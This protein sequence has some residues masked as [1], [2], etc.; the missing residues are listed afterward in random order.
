VNLRHL[1]LIVALTRVRD[2]DVAAERLLAA[3]RAV[4]DRF[5][6]YR[7]MFFLGAWGVIG[8]SSVDQALTAQRRLRAM[9]DGPMEQAAVAHM[10]GL[11]RGMRGEFEE[12]RRL[13]REARARAA[14]FGGDMTGVP[15]ARDEALV[16]R[17]AGDATA[18]ERTLRPACD[19]L[20]AAGDVGFLSLLVG[21]L[22][23]ALYELG[24]YREAAEANQESERA[25]QPADVA[26]EVVWR[27]VR[28]KLLA[29]EG[30][31]EAAVSLAREAIAW[32]ETTDVLEMVGDAYRDLS[33]VE[34]LGGRPEKAASALQRA[35]AAYERKGL[36]PMAERTRK[37]LEELRTAV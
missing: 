22:A 34:R 6:S 16:E 7:A 3:A 28:A 14:D 20:R 35:L 27:R 1:E 17:Y 9:A 31:Y 13:I 32:A 24:R 2:L 30:N 36:V 23:D 29:R 4:G 5:G 18:V 33:E 10:E 25:T 19:A 12:A 26:A 15:T 37:E 11:L 21:E 8:P